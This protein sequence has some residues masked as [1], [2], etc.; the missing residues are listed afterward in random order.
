MVGQKSSDPFPIIDKLW[1]LFAGKGIRTVFLSVGASNSAVADLDIAES[2]GCPLH[3]VPLGSNQAAGWSEVAQYLKDRKRP[4][5]ASA[6]S[7]GVD[8]K[9]VLPKNIRIQTSVPWWTAGQID[10]SGT[11]LSTQ[12]VGDMVDSISSGMKIKD[13]AKRIDL[14]KVDTTGL[15][16]G[17]EIPVINS[18]LSAGYRPSIILVKWG[19]MPDTDSTAMIAAGHLQCCGY[20]LMDTLENKFVYYYNDDNI[21]EICSWEQRSLMNP[22]VHEIIKASSKRSL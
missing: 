20:T 13:T 4:E 16:P 22:I 19:Y 3:I 12:P 8:T 5:S 11:L 17:L 7:E 2:I 15:S 10:I 14:L 21:Y 9:W 1:D 18:I 6:F